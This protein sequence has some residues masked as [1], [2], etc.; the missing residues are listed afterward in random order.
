MGF[1][2]QWC[3]PSRALETAFTS[4]LTHLSDRIRLALIDVAASPRAAE[5]HGVAGLPTLVVIKE[6][7]E[8][9]RRVGLMSPEDLMKLIERHV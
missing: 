7:R 4:A 9:A 5:H 6:G 8:V 3:V 2:A 1:W